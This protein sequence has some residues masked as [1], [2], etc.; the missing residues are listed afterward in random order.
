[1]HSLQIFSIVGGK[2]SLFLSRFLD[3]LKSL[4]IRHIISR[5]FT[6]ELSYWW[7]V[8]YILKELCVRLRLFRPDRIR[9]NFWSGSNR[10]TRIWSLPS[11]WVQKFF[12]LAFFLC[13]M[14]EGEFYILQGFGAL[15]NIDYSYLWVS[16]G[17]KDSIFRTY[18]FVFHHNLFRMLELVFNSPG[19]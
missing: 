2:K 14:E 15:W 3:L 1:M 18:N 9:R 13:L 4:N 6:L 5:T 10:S 19:I 11:L 16:M 17:K 8:W 12:C 7:K